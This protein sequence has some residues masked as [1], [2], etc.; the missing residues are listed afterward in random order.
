MCSEVV[1]NSS[2]FFRATKRAFRRSGSVDVS[3]V[4]VGRDPFRHR[5][6]THS[7]AQYRI[8]SFRRSHSKNSN[9]DRKLKKEF[10]ILILE[11]GTENEPSIKTPTIHD[12]DRV[13]HESEETKEMDDELYN[14]RHPRFGLAD[15]STILSDNV[16]AQ[17]DPFSWE[18]LQSQVAGHGLDGEMNTNNVPGVLITSGGQILKPVQESRGFAGGLTERADRGLT[19]VAFYS[20][21]RKSND[22]IDAKIRQCIPAF[23][24]IEQFESSVNENPI[25]SSFL[26]LEDITEGFKLP[27]VMD[28]K[29]GKKVYV[30]DASADKKARHS[31][32]SNLWPTQKPLGFKVSGVKAHSLDPKEEDILDKN[33]KVYGKLNFGKKLTPS[34]IW[35]ITEAFYD[36]EK[37]EVIKVVNDVFVTKLKSILEVFEAQRKFHIH[38]SS[39]L[40]TYDANAVR[41]FHNGNLSKDEVESFVNIKLIDFAN[42][43]E[44]DGEKDENFISGLRNVLILFES[45][46]KDLEKN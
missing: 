6:Q 26:I 28:I 23:H 44:A 9:P 7:T 38:G 34:T 14:M 39:L 16:I 41:K 46:S 18:P 27:A 5:A 32:S 31:C 13:F 35:K 36:S 42:V 4:Q 2:L 20:Y 22:V 1:F 40:F 21:L 24:G 10:S 25:L 17:N 29:I 43:Y 33:G 11:T 8:A 45:F 15:Y 3:G 12:N 37:S 19:E 30:P